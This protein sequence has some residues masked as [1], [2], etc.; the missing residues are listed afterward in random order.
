MAADTFQIAFVTR[1]GNTFHYGYDH[2][3]YLTKEI[4]KARK[5]DCNFYTTKAS[6]KEEA[7]RLKKYFFGND[8]EI[9]ALVLE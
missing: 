3:P 4:A 2:F 9:T 5:L 7:E 8:C 6:R 1:N